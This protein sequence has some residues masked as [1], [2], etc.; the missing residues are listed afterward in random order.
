MAW[1]VLIAAGVMESVWAV[2]LGKSE[3]FSSVV[4][5]IIFFGAL[6]L[7]MI[8]LSWAMKTI[9][10]GTAYSVWVGIGAAL[11]VLYEMATGDQQFSLVRAALIAGLVLCVVG[12]KILD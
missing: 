4:P 3:H 7:S 5:T 11:T 9:P 10:L 8:G 1:T 12:L 6:A 2:A